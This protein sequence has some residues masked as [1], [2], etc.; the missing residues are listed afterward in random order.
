M[1]RDM[2]VSAYLHGHG[3]RLRF[4]GLVALWNVVF[5]ALLRAPWVISHAAYPLTALQA[6]L[7]AWYGGR[8][9]APVVV[10]LECSGTDVMALCTGIVLAYPATWRRRLAGIGL[11][12]P[13]LFVVNV[14]RIG[15]LSRAAGS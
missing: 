8:S 15:T 12:L 4:L 5:F 6:A 9:D 1:S 7:A 10:T 11:I 2:S 3:D 14:V 13:V